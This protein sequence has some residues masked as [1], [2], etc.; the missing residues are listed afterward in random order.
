MTPV[1]PSAHR[2][3]LCPQPTGLHWELGHLQDSG[4]PK[5]L[6][7]W[8]P[9]DHI[10]AEVPAP[11]R[12][13]L[14]R[15]L[16]ALGTTAFLTPLE[17]APAH[18][19]S[20]WSALVGKVRASLAAGTG[21]PTGARW[22]TTQD[23]ETAAMLFDQPGFAWSMRAQLALV[24]SNGETPLPAP[25]GEVLE[26]LLTDG[27]P[28]HGQQG[29]F[30][31][32]VLA[33]LRPGVDGDVALLSC[34]DAAVLAAFRTTLAQEAASAAIDILEVDEPAFA[35]Q[36]AGRYNLTTSSDSPPRSRR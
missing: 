18:T 21:R 7:G 17:S 2:L 27:W 3:L 19:A 11:I 29:Q 14:S 33:S 23:A 1:P 15:T 12:G 13:V 20:G 8:C 28:G 10:D 24:L 34:A 31:A 36:L 9:V 5:L 16:V 35:D 26:R 25:S 6:L 30:A 4:L 22:V 32:G